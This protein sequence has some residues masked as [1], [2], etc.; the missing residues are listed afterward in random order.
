MEKLKWIILG[1]LL[2]VLVFVIFRN[3]DIEEEIVQ[4]NHAK[5]QVTISD[6]LSETSTEIK[7]E[8]GEYILYLDDFQ[9]IEGN[10]TGWHISFSRPVGD[11]EMILQFD[12]VDTSGTVFTS[13][14]PQEIFYS[15][16]RE[17]R[18]LPHQPLYRGFFKMGYKKRLTS[19][20][21][22]EDLIPM[23]EFSCKIDTAW[24][25]DS[26]GA[27]QMSFNATHSELLHSVYG[28]KY[29]ISGT[30]NIDNASVSKRLIQ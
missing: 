25:S 20:T 28:M 18:S 12:V 29:S 11:K 7:I 19:A 14:Y 6:I 16:Y 1:I 22:Q 2:L 24:T 10:G 3:P 9:V 23:L 30:F 21:F 4:E 5:I 8:Q 26:L 27:L 17:N 15:L 13:E